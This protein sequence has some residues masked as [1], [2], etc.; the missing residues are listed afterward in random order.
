MRVVVPQELAEGER[1]VAV[2]PD[3]TAR[4]IAAGCS[5]AVQAGAGLG[6]F[7]ADDDIAARG[8][9]IGTNRSALLGSADVVLS[10]Q[11]I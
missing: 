5:V 2:V 7:V 4:L 1:R 9:E 3:T 8:A 10:V 6:A 11:P